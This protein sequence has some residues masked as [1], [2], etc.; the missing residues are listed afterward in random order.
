MILA[1]FLI[2]VLVLWGVL[3]FNLESGIRRNQ[4]DLTEP[5]LPRLAGSVADEAEEWLMSRS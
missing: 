4:I 5:Q 1:A 2:S 3:A